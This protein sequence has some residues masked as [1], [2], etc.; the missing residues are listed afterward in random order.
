MMGRAW[1]R[2]SGAAVVAM[3]LGACGKSKP[4]P[5]EG[6]GI[7]RPV[8]DEPLPPDLKFRWPS[9]AEVMVTLRIGTEEA[10]MVSRARLTLGPPDADGR[11]RLTQSA[12]E[13]VGGEAAELVA[14]GLSMAMRE[15]E[16]LIAPDGTTVD[17]EAGALWAIFVEGW[18]DFAELELGAEQTIAGG[19]D[20]VPEGVELVVRRRASNWDD[21]A[22]LGYRMTATSPAGQDNLRRQMNLGAR[23]GQPRWI[24][25]EV[26]LEPRT[27]QPIQVVIRTELEG[28]KRF[29]MHFEFDWQSNGS[30]RPG[31]P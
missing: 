14:L 9:P 10:T 16:I 4:V 6:S 1:L 17:P 29:A 25:T 5:P 13:A 28:D 3:A 27:M 18:L 8:V 23:H 30:S 15:E 22:R 2:W 31:A 21:A 19:T 7:A 26:D 12:F 11:R 24:D 20:G